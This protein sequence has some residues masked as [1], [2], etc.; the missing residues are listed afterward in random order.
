MLTHKKHTTEHAAR[1]NPKW[2]QTHFRGGPIQQAEVVV[3]S[4]LNRTVAIVTGVPWKW[5]NTFFKFNQF[6]VLNIKSKI[7]KENIQ[8]R[9]QYC[10]LIYSVDNSYNHSLPL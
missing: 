10:K 1:L 7:Y 9:K 3:F 2:R 5:C 8:T 6:I 4:F